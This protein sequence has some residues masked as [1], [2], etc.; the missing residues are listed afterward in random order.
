MKPLYILSTVQ[1]DEVE[2]D[3][4]PV[5]PDVSYKSFVTYQLNKCYERHKERAFTF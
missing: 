4:F 5:D 2:V 1:E 3:E